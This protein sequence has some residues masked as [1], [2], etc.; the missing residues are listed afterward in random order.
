MNVNPISASP[1]TPAGSGDPVAKTG[2]DAA[3][4][5]EQFLTLLVTQL[6]YQNPL[7]PQD[8]SQF[9]SQLAQMS[10]LT[11]LIEIRQGLES[12]NESF[13]GIAALAPALGR[14]LAAGDPAAAVES[15]PQEVTS[16]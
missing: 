11:E 10:S 13:A 7:N 12:L 2:V 15:L 3:E 6:R 14:L 16:V 9:L 1:V 5:S 8:G 4:L